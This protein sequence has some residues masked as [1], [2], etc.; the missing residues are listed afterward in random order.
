MRQVGL[1]LLACEDRTAVRIV[2]AFNGVGMGG[3]KKWKELREMERLRRR[4]SPAL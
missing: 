3:A 2:A 4:D 1:F